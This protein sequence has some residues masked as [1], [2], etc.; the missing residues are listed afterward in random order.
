MTAPSGDSGRM[1]AV[2][3]LLKSYK[4]GGTFCTTVEAPA[5]VSLPT[6]IISVSWMWHALS[7]P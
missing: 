5:C 7:I 1:G 6:A 4:N 2:G 3:L